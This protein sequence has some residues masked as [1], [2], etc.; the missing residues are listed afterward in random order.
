MTE[1][2]VNQGRRIVEG[3]RRLVA[4]LPPSSKIREDAETLLSAF[5]RSQGVFDADL[6]DIIKAQDRA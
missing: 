5:E 2:H 3:Q 4:S 1:R 6:A